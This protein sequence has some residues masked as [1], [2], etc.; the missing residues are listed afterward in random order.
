M[1][2]NIEQKVKRN[3][4]KYCGLKVDQTNSVSFHWAHIDPTTKSFTI[5]NLVNDS[6]CF[7]TAKSKMDEEIAKC[8]LKCAACHKKETDQRRDLL[9]Y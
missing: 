8:E 2:H 9:L 6:R 1:E 4:C 3:Q 7:K 5:S